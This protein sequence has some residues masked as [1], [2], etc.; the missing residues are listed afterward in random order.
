MAVDISNFTNQMR[1]ILKLVCHSTTLEVN[2]N[3]GHLIR[4]EL[5][6]NRK[7]IRLHDFALT[8]TCGACNK[9]MRA[10]GFFVQ[11]KE[12]L[13]PLHINAQWCRKGTLDIRRFPLRG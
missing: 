2:D 11:I 12:Y 9:A 3:K 5:R 10:M 7:D 1:Q 8:R 6:S 13:T 4:M